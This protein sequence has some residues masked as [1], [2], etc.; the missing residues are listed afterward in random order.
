MPGEVDLDD[1]TFIRRPD[2]REVSLAKP[3]LAIARLTL[4][5]EHL[6]R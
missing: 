2:D 5:D 6:V 1:R 4:P 3:E